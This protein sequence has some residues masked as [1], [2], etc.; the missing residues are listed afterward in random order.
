MDKKIY[1]DHDGCLAVWREALS[2]RQC[3]SLLFMKQLSRM[4][5]S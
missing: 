3:T 1:V 4:Y 2:E 5:Q